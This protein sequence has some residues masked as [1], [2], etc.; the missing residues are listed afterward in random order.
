MKA[1]GAIAKVQGDAQ[2]TQIQA[3]QAQ[4][5]DSIEAFKAETDRAAL[6]NPQVQ[7]RSVI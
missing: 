7:T 3:V 6:M 2:K 1:Q 4:R 5:K